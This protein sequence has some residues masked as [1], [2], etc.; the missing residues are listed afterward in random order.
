MYCIQVYDNSRGEPRF[1][2]V[3]PVWESAVGWCVLYPEH[4]VVP[5]EYE[6]AA[7]AIRIAKG[8]AVSLRM[9]TAVVELKTGARVFDSLD[10]PH[11]VRPDPAVT[12]SDL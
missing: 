1:R 11:S 10:W 12:Q 7:D 8:M 4:G 3:R 5:S 9:R 2:Q 6:I